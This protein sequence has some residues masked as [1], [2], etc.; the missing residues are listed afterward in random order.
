M[1]IFHVQLCSFLCCLCDT[2]PTICRLLLY[3]LLELEPDLKM[4]FTCLKTVT[5]SKSILIQSSL[6]WL[7][8]GWLRG[9]FK[10][11]VLPK[12]CSL[13]RRCDCHH[14]ILC[15]AGLCIVIEFILH[16]YIVHVDPMY[17]GDGIQKSHPC[18]ASFNRLPQV[19]C[20]L[21]TKL[22]LKIAQSI[23]LQWGHL[24][25]VSSLEE[26]VS[27]TFHQPQRTKPDL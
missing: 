14:S 7:R 27:G 1:V 16:I 4:T 26:L 5:K 6:T 13:L 23:L 3:S 9:N 24:V 11:D 15:C 25:E 22:E 20:K 12:K 17:N 19:D 8:K 10:H 18:G 2:H 21:P